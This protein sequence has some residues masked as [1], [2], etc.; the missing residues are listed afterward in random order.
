VSFKSKAD[1]ADYIQYRRAWQHQLSDVC[2]LGVD[3]QAH[4][5]KV[6]GPG[7]T[8]QIRTGYT[9]N[10][11]KLFERALATISVKPDSLSSPVATREGS[12]NTLRHAVRVDL[13]SVSRLTLPAWQRV[14]KFICCRIG[15]IG[16]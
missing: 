1:R 10:D 13:D 3:S 7:E 16:G 6:D 15:Q 14:G 5:L 4:G 9:L 2:I 12:R 8:V 11:R